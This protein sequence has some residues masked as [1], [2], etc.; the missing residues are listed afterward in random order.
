MTALTNQ[1]LSL[2]LI[3]PIKKQI[4]GKSKDICSIRPHWEEESKH[5]NEAPSASLWSKNEVWTSIE[6]RGSYL[7]RYGP[8][9]H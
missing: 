2:V 5:F 4:R 3:K 7:S 9:H 6:G 8:V 1:A